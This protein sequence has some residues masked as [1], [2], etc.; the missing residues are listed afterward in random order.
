MPAERSAVRSRRDCAFRAQ[1]RASCEVDSAGGLRAVRGLWSPQRETSRPGQGSRRIWT[2][3]FGARPDSG[4]VTISA[5]AGADVS[6]PRLPCLKLL[7]LFFDWFCFVTGSRFAQLPRLT[8]LLFFPLHHGGRHTLFQEVVDHRLLLR[9]GHAELEVLG[10][11][12]GLG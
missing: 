10:V 3:R 2:V 8:Q 5:T 11:C 4:T 6:L 12:V 7:S 9:R 1:T